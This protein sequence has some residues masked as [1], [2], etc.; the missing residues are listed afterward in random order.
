MVSSQTL[1]TTEKSIQILEL[2]KEKNGAGVTELANELSIP[3][4][5]VHSHLAT[6]KKHELVIKQNGEYQLGLRFLALGEYVRSTKPFYDDAYSLVGKLAE[7]TEGRAHF[8]VEEYGKSVYLFTQGGKYAINA[9]PSI[10]KRAHLHATAAGKSI[11]AHLPEKRIESILDK[12]GLPAVTE[13][14]IT[15]RA[16]LMTELEDVREQGY[17][18]NN[19]EHISGIR[20]VGA[21]VLGKNDEIFGSFSVSSSKQRF[22]DEYFYESVPSTVLG[23]ANELELTISYQ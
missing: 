7:E 15:D 11:L 8:V 18:F 10:G 20:A 17:A 6:L 21:P 16:E 2:L 13:S 1:S 23:I 3:P 12:H 22:K 14:T 19:E 4:S 5:T 9:Y